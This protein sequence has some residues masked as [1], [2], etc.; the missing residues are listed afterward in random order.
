MQRYADFAFL[1]RVWEKYLYRILC[2][3]FQKDLSIML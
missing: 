1:E 3:I 2:M